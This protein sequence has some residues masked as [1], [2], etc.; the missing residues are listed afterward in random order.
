MK[1]GGGAPGGGETFAERLRV[2]LE[3][4]SDGP[5]IPLPH[6]GPL[7]IEVRFPKKKTAGRVTVNGTI[8]LVIAGQRREIPLTLWLP[9]SHLRS[10]ARRAARPGPPSA[11]LVPGPAGSARVK[12][13]STDLDHVASLVYMRLA[14]YRG[15]MGLPARARR[16]TI[17]LRMPPPICAIVKIRHDDMVAL[18]NA[19]NDE[20]N[21]KRNHERCRT[22]LRL[23]LTHELLGW[24]LALPR[25]KSLKEWPLRRALPAAFGS[26]R[27]LVRLARTDT[28]LAQRIA[29]IINGN[30]R[31]SA[32]CDNYADGDE[33]A[34]LARAIALVDRAFGGAWNK[35]KVPRPCVFHGP[36]GP[37]NALRRYSYGKKSEKLRA[38]LADVRLDPASPEDLRYFAERLL[39]GEPGVGHPGRRRR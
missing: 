9:R 33:V 23:M 36:K 18:D 20:Q 14:D 12:A 13:P 2:E 6:T 25:G 29:G 5:R 19:L 16:Q 26:A 1:G 27:N 17:L 30:D 7:R 11:V 24:S 35:Y 37:T 22:A 34:D 15:A 21:R 8:P 4:R 39:L 31:L 28:Q 38:L 32:Y 3:I 10:A